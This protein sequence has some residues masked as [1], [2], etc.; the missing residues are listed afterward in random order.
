MMNAS[1]TRRRRRI[2][3]GLL[4]LIMISAG[5][6]AAPA[7]A[8]DTEP[9][10]AG[11]GKADPAAVEFFE[12]DVRPILATRCQGCHGPAKQKG[13]LRLDARASILAG[14]TS[15][16]A[17]VPGDPK[18]SLLVDAINYGETYQMPP[19]SKLPD[20]EIATLTRW[21]Q[22]GAPWGFEAE[23]TARGKVD[24]TSPDSKDPRS[25]G[26]DWP[27]EFRT[28]SQHWSFQPIRR[29]TPPAATGP[30]GWARN[31]IDSFILAR[32]AEHGLQPAPEANRRTLIRR[33]SYDLTGL[34]PAPGDVASFLADESPEAYER[35]VERLLAS[36]RY[37]E[38]W[39][40]H[41]L[42]LVRYAE[43]AGHEFDYD[44]INASRYRDYVI[45][46]LNADL[47]YD[48]FV[49]EQL[50]GDLVPRPRR[51]P[52]EGFN[53]SI[54]G[55]GFYYL[56]EGT[57]SPVDVR[58]EEV[59][60][61][62]NQID[63]I[64][65]AF[66]GLTVACARCHDHK[67]DP[68]GN[69]DYYAL[70][71]FLRSSRYQQAF[72]DPPGRVDGPLGRLEDSRKEIVALL[73][74]A[75][76]ALPDRLRD[77]TAR[78]LRASDG[79]SKPR[80]AAGSSV[81]LPTEIVFEDFHRDSYDGWFAT[82]AAFGDRPTR[83]SDLRLDLSGNPA[84]LTR[85][86]PG[87]AHSGVASDRLCGV[88][89]S[90]TFTIENRY[91]HYR[92]AGRGGVL[93]VVVDGFEKIRDPIYGGL[94]TT[95]NIGDRSRWVTQ[96]VGMWLG[97][98]AYLEIADGSIADY[99]G[100]TTRIHDGRGYI[101]VD[102]IRMSNQ[103]A[104]A[105]SPDSAEDVLV[106]LDEV[107]STLR[108]AQ[109]RLADRL[110]AAVAGARSA[111]ARIPDP[112]LALA[113]AD[114][115]GLDERILI[116][117]N[118]KSPGEVVPRRFLEVLGGTGGPTPEAG[119]G[120]L[121]LARRVVDPRSNPLTPRVLVNRLWKH[122]FGEGIVKSTD[123][124]GAMGRKPSHP[125][126]LDW[127]A[128]ELVQRGWSI[129]SIQ[130]LIVTSS[131]YRM[132]SV[133]IEEAE[134][135][136]PENIAL[137]R[138]NVRRLEAEAVRDG[139]LAVSGRLV[140]TMYGPSVPTHLTSFMDGRGRPGRS[141]PL[142]GDGRRSIYLSVRRNFINPMFL[143]FDTPVPFSTMGRRNVSNV[144]AQALILLNDPM[145]ILQ[146][147]RWSERVALAPGRSDRHRLDELFLSALGRP[148]TA[149]EVRAC[150]DFLDG[151]RPP[152][153]RAPSHAPAAGAKRNP[154][155]WA[156]LCHV[157]INMKEFIFI[158]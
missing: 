116:R 156:D 110:A 118:H 35:L 27:T 5:S 82:G 36:P 80:D 92:V 157:L 158:D 57:H 114:G 137:H 147:R 54:I 115:S 6:P 14:G 108:A 83:S 28:R 119:S 3:S 95:V 63:V 153:D 101:A 78:V 133:P 127:L 51:H 136:D 25:K 69:H 17:V 93:N 2:V 130:R 154:T 72:I 11:A 120:R 71:G 24:P 19:K 146:A 109:D 155:A 45:R 96:D 117:G 85:V 41:W 124:F 64:S 126:L 86:A 67:F 44:L 1:E 8:G 12:K 59:R 65:K 68:I 31:S 22:M 39:A 4:S 55:T 148:P 18:E 97:H 84:R 47:P 98:T 7:R 37:G 21:V 75:E 113:I 125:E 20:G 61:I 123:D 99:Q 15:G 30:L 100:G 74:S 151:S 105:A 66:L 32:L 58:E 77:Q 139:L 152:G 121:E 29:G 34:P 111:E 49:V 132:S 40:R 42:D 143:A 73:A 102:E 103:P 88:L 138:M 144:P 149:D 128:S 53:E 9:K 141:G 50:A 38:R 142:D 60:R 81:G 52:I 16:P 48:Q 90:R 104:P 140:E 23:S 94:T 145:A 129:K 76:P 87:M 79:A 70:A 135:I 13:G 122:H 26:T 89:R 91:I 131:T 106:D 46:A 33:L 56:G 107:I 10:R 112:N 150:L 43:T 134:R 62:D